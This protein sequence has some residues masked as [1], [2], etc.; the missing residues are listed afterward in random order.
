MTLVFGSSSG[1]EIMYVHIYIY[2]YED[3]RKD[4]AGLIICDKD[5]SGSS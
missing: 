5:R 4:I 2:I 1:F 3:G